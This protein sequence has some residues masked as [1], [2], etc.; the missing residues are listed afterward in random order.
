MSIFGCGQNEIGLLVLIVAFLFLAGKLGAILAKRLKLPAVLGELGAGMALSTAPWA[1]SLLSVI[2][3]GKIFEGIA[4]IGVLLLMFDV[5][6][7]TSLSGLLSVGVTATRVAIVGIVAPFLLGVAVTAWMLPE[8]SPWAYIFLGATLTATS[9]GITARVFKDA[10]ALQSEAARIVLGAAVIDDILG[11]VVLA[12]VQA[13]ILHAAAGN[14]ASLDVLALL[15]IGAKAAAFIALA[16][17]VGRGVVPRFEAKLK[18]LRSQ[19]LK[20]GFA[21]LFAAAFAALA[22]AAGLAPIVGAFTAGLLLRGDAGSAADANEAHENA[23]SLAKLLAPLSAIFVPLF[24]VIMGMRVDLRHNLNPGVLALALVLS[25][26]AIVS[27]QVCGLVLPKGAKAS[28][29]V[30]GLGMVPRGEVGL[31]FAMIG[32]TLSVGGQMIVDEKTYAAIVIMVMVTTLITPL[33]LTWAMARAAPGS[34]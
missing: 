14:G 9:I 33:A 12:V 19:H 30:V 18:I 4:M 5:G 17:A 10:K 1:L 3:G 7:E 31:I 24:F 11:L 34:T 29:L 23:A 20:L 22:A 15:S 26:V 2:G 8:Q 27:K 32:S 21:L 28:R 16:I 6:L 13:L 25:G